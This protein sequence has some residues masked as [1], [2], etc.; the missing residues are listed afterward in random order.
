M[1]EEKETIEV[2][3]ISEPLSNLKHEL[4]CQ[5]YVNNSILFGNA[6][7]SYNEA[8]QYNLDDLP[9]DDEVWDNDKKSKTYG[10]KLKKSSYDLASN[11]CAVE[12]ARLL[13]NPQVNQRITVL[14]NELLKDEVVDGQLAK[15]IMQDKDIAPKVQAIKAYNDI[16]GRVIKRT[17][18]TT[19]GDKIEG[20]V[21]LPAKE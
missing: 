14:L 5:Y 1:S 15:V 2:K 7:H 9:D 12:G 10:K 21:I 3:T 13:R 18:L 4:F 6:T 20:V 19:G 11:V 17:D 8:Y 16:R